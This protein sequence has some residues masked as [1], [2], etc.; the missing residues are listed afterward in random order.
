MFHSFKSLIAGSALALLAGSAAVGAEFTFKLHHFLGA[1]S[2]SQTETIEPWAKA[3]EE[4]SGGRVKIEIFPSMSLGGTPPELVGQ[5]R[6][7]VVDLVW[8][9]NGYTPGVFP[10]TE[11]FELPFVHRND[12]AATNLAMAELFDTELR[13]E[14]K[15]LEVM[16]LHVHGGHG[17]HTV[18]REVRTPDDLKGLKIRTPSRTGAW[19]IEALGASPVAMP[20]PSLPQAL[21]TKAV[22]A[23]FVPWEI[24]P[25]LKLQDQTNFQIEGADRTRFGTL[26]FQL[27]MNQ[28]RWNSLPEDIQSAFRKASSPDWLAH[29]GKVWAQTDDKGIAIAV[30]AGNSHIVLT[31]DQTKTFEQA[32]KPVIDRWVTEATNNGI[33]GADLLEK[34][35]S[36]L[37]KHAK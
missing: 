16:F 5:A 34:A 23:A 7:G 4:A 29:L 15:G 33:N 30:D 6:D 31:Q 36:A 14:Y 9:V 26:V 17:L 25:A 18:D 22:D 21:Q 11:V 10:R 37:A 28:G 27:S 20:V 19:T 12:P 3:V 8:T 13:Q 35:Q 24:I 32:L 1:T 2:P